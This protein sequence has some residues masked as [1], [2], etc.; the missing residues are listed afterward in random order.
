MTVTTAGDMALLAQEH[1]PR[2]VRVA[3]S[4]RAGDAEEIAAT[5]IARLA[6]HPDRPVG[7]G[8]ALSYIMRAVRNQAVNAMR[9][10]YRHGR[11]ELAYGARMRE[12]APDPAESAATSERLAAVR[13]A[14]SALTPKEREAVARVA[15]GLTVGSA[16]KVR[17]H[18]ARKKL[19]ALAPP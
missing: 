17:L 5:V 1:W 10:R 2:L 7:K 13:A 16:G 6:G 18:Y 19:L 14:L 11:R 15:A 8:S 9:E 4:Y 12:P 3:A